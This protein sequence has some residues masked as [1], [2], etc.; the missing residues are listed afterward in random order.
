MLIQIGSAMDEMNRKGFMHRD[1]KPGNILL[2]HCSDCGQ[3]VTE[4]PGYLLSFKLGMWL[5]YDYDI[6]LLN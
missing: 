5:F 6:C 4:I 1:L 3:S 2:S